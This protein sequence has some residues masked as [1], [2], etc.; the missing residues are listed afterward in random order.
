MYLPFHTHTH[1]LKCT[2]TSERGVRWNATRIHLK[3]HPIGCHSV[4]SVCIS[5]ADVR[6]ASTMEKWRFTIYARVSF[7][8]K[9]LHNNTVA[10]QTYIHRSTRN[11]SVTSQ[12]IY[13]ALCSA[14]IHTISMLYMHTNL[15][16]SSYR[17]SHL[18][19]VFGFVCF[20]RRI[21][22]AIMDFQFQYTA[23]C[24]FHPKRYIRFKR[25][26]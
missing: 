7:Y 13:E 12:Y 11:E 24:W 17:Q 19:C 14:Y 16:Y 25:L 18:T 15:R 22:L 10:T 1:I 5:C 26:V 3:V 21:R 9:K 6:M 4:L 2:R 8:I 20:F 23:S